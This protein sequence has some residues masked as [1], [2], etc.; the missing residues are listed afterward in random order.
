MSLLIHDQEDWWLVFPHTITATRRGVQVLLSFCLI[1]NNDEHLH[2]LVQLDTLH[3][4]PW[5]S[6]EYKACLK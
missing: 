4:P 5:S 3:A 6:I 2:W 1:I